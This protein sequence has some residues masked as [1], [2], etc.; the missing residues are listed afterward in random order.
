M[1]ASFRMMEGRLSQSTWTTSSKH[2][3]FDANVIVSININWL[4]LIQRPCAVSTGR[5]KRTET[6]RFFHISII[7]AIVIMIIY[8]HIIMITICMAMKRHHP[9]DHHHDHLARNIPH[10][11]WQGVLRQPSL[12]IQ[13]Q[14]P[15]VR[16]ECWRPR[17]RLHWRRW[18]LWWLRLI[19][20]SFFSK[21][22]WISTFDLFRPGG[23]GQDGREQRR[24]SISFWHQGI[25]WQLINIRGAVILSVKK[26][27]EDVRFGKVMS[28]L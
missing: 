8:P 18:L 23:L 14:D 7:I 22:F 5:Q 28:I 3:L 15:L 11:P 26:T 27:S 4:K 9:P 17:R 6:I 24:H 1:K 25:S 10:G 20:I 19:T 2:K 13:R 12:D 16:S 21:I